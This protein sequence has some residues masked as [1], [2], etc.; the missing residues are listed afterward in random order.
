MGWQAF[1]AAVCF[2]AGTIMQGLIAF[3]DETYAWHRWQG[4][5]LTIGCVSFA[6]LF[7]TVFAHQL[8]LFEG[9]VLIVHIGKST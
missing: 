7:N 4:T 2:G 9:S 1:L 3:N 6:I 8:P 5:M